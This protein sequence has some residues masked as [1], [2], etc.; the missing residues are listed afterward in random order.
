TNS[1][2]QPTPTTITG[3]KPKDVINS[4]SQPETTTSV[5]QATKTSSSPSLPNTQV[6]AQP[7][8]K[9]AHLDLAYRSFHKPGTI[10]LI[11]AGINP[12]FVTGNEGTQSL[13]KECG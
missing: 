2:S 8:Q 3:S 1:S 4:S 13:R 10:D 11:S 6:P 9:V 12:H 5:S 7:L